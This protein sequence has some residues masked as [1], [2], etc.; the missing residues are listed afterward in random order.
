MIN[1]AQI[2]QR[3]EKENLSFNIVFKEYLH[4]VVLNFLF[5]KGL[6]DEI[7]FQGGT[8]LRFA[9]GSVRYSE[10]LDF[11]LK[12]RSKRFFKNIPHFLEPL[13]KYLENWIPSLKQANLKLQKDTDSFQRY[14]LITEV[15]LPMRDRT[16]LEFAFVPSYENSVKILKV[17]GYL[18]FPAVSVETPDEILSDKFIAIGSRKYLKGRDIW[19]I[20]F[21]ND[22]LS[23]RITEKVLKMVERKILDYNLNA[24]EFKNGL[25]KSI[26]I[27][28]R[29][30]K[31][32][33]ES[34]ME[35]F[36][37]ENYRK[38]FSGNYGTICEKV[39]KILE[40]IEDELK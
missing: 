29:N 28:K 32:F 8:A 21:L 27:L 6:F 13:S 14:I 3:A 10:D 16:S 23:A 25:K 34:E 22:V 15:N 7:V 39:I 1:L 26:S 9:Y 33:L 11:V 35:R 18:L 30:G 19:D 31:K 36:L 37:P 40:E 2:A 20:Y 38:I 24:P 4:L 5:E 17:E 12:K